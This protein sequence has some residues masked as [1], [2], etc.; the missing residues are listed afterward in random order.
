MTTKPYQI[1]V[2]GA[3]G[4]TATICAEH[5]A[6]S[7][8]ADAKWCIAGRSAVKLQALRR[9]LQAIDPDRLEPTIYVIPQLDAQGLDP[10]IKETDVLINGIG[11][12]HRYGTPVVES[13]ARNGTHY[14]DFSTETMW[15]SEMIRD[16][17]AVAK[18]S[19]AIVIPA[20]SGSSAPSDLIAWLIVRHLQNQGLPAPH[21]VVCAGKLNMLG[22][23]GGS[24]HTVLDVAER[25]G[26]SGWLTS[27][28]SILS[29]SAKSPVKVRR[30]LFGHRYDR[31]LGHL[32]MS[33]VAWGNESVVNRSAALDQKT[34]G[35]QFVFREYVPSTGFISAVMVY[36]ITKLGIVLLAIPWFRS[37]IRTRSFDRGTGPARTESRKVE[38]AEWKGVAYIK[39]TKNPVAIARFNYD[40]ALVDMAAILAVEA[41]AAINDSLRTAASGYLQAGI[42]TP[43]TLGTLFVSRLQ[44][45]GFE[46]EV[47]GGN[48]H[49]Q[50][51]VMM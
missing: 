30:G 6:K 37:F 7:F 33:F 34:Y 22:M 42:V 18:A 48:G 38:S 23:Q 29:P 12:Y 13:C 41:A 4:W 44:A 3:T 35:Q 28:M 43:S 24:L 16:Y 11:P 45:V 5:I 19:G 36:I 51:P 50:K 10:I 21:E 15:I 32:A 20:I 26:V 31:H 17:H 49:L 46:V 47:H 2:L 14:V 27:D 40:G 39:G 25:Y 1:T 8:P 9:S